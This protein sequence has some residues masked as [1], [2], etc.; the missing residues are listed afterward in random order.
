M[1]SDNI[2]TIFTNP[3]FCGAKKYATGY[4]WLTAVAPAD[5]AT[6]EFSLQIATNDYTL[7]TTY[8]INLVV[9]FVNPLYLG[10]LT[11]TLSLTLLHPCKLTLITTSQVINPITYPFGG[12]AVFTA[13]TN[14]ADTVSAQYSLPTLCGLIYS[15][16]VAADAT[17]Y[18]V[19]IIT[20]SPN[21]IRVVTNTEALKGTSVS[22][23]MSANATP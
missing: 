4:G 14:F 9:S 21:Q 5:P 15:L 7:A 20:G 1:N 2:G 12:A 22:L 13:Y 23:T 11:Q 18:G 17:N 8:T 3:I 10:T 19:T 16:S 6:Q